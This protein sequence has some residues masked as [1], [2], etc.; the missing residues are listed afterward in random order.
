[1]KCFVIYEPE[2]DDEVELGHKGVDSL[3]T[4]DIDELLEYIEE[5]MEQRDVLSIDIDIEVE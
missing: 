3:E 5:K 4:C 2:E 1:M